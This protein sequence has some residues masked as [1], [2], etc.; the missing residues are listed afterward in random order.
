LDVSQVMWNFRLWKVIDITNV[1]VLYITSAH[2]SW[3]RWQTRKRDVD[4]LRI[5]SVMVRE[6][7]P[8]GFE[9][10]GLIVYGRMN[11]YM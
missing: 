1:L 8:V 11:E 3:I 7:S 5:Q 2:S 4:V 9:Y 10:C 6:A